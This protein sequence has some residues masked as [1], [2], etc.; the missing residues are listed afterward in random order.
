MKGFATSDV[1]K[2]RKVNED[3][4][5]I[6]LKED[7]IQL[8]VVADGMGGYEKG[9][10]ASL[11]A[12]TSVRD[13]VLE[14][15]DKYE[16]PK[17]NFLKLLK[18]ATQYANMVVYNKSQESATKELM[19]TTLDTCLFYKNKIYISH[20]GDSRIYRIRKGIIRRLTKDHSYVQE[21]VDEGKITKE[22]AKDHPKKNMIMK[23]IGIEESIEP[24]LSIK[25]FQKDDIVLMC[26]DGLTNMVPD[27]EIL[28]ILNENPTDC[29]TPL[30]QK[31]NANGGADNITA[32]VIRE[33]A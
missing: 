19:G 29:T 24:D 15:Y 10:V 31:A 13:Y 7:K 23:A 18:E 16:E 17:D 1:G 6:S 11:L 30:G 22:E 9:E 32:G 33:N 8:Y 2:I 20:I 12:V 4:Y 14:N 27:D 26:S 25:G 5:F 21:L 3:A 28:K